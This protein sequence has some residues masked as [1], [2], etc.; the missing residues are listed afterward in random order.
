MVTARDIIKEALTDLGV[1][2]DGKSPSASQALGGLGKLNDMLDAWNNSPLMVY[3]ASSSILPF[4][5]NQQIYTIGV[6]GNLNIPYPS[7]KIQSA[8]VRDT[9]LPLAQ[10]MDYPLYLY[11]NQEWADV[12]FKGLSADWPNWG[13]WFDYNYPL[14]NA[15]MNPIPSGSQYSMVIWVPGIIANLTLDQVVALP[16]GY[17]RCISSNLCPELEGSYGVQTPDRILEIAKDSMAN[18]K[19]SNLQ[20]NELVIDPV[21]RSNSRYDI[22]TGR[23]T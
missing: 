14:I 15:Y 20:I 1:L 16:A 8:Y 7:N 22:R 6:G 9:S 2:A 10:Q 21:L 11:N 13:V 3:G 5:A 23:Y 17:K 18:I 19:V 12:R 4:V